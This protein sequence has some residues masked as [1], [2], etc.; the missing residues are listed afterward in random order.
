M[1]GS[2]QVISPRIIIFENN[3]NNIVELRTIVWQHL[4]RKIKDTKL[5]KAAIVFTTIIIT[6][7]PLTEIKCLQAYLC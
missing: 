1:K 4:P 2:I 6:F 7:I 5:Q 3:Y